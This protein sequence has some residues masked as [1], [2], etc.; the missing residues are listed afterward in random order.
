MK[1]GL[2]VEER[3]KHSFDS[4]R[5]ANRTSA[6]GINMMLLPENTRQD[7]I[8]SIMF[9]T[10]EG[11]MFPEDPFAKK[12]DMAASQEAISFKPEGDLEF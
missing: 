7:I 8:G 6:Y 2:L 12:A 11:S 9:Q 10:S 4:G 5:E 1:S 3:S